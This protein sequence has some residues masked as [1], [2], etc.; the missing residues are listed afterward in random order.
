[1]QKIDR[2]DVHHVVFCAQ[3]RYRL[4]SRTPS[5]GKEC[6]CGQTQQKS[7]TIQVETQPKAVFLPRPTM[8]PHTQLTGL[9]QIS[10]LNFPSTIL[11]FGTQSRKV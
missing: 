9:L 6:P 2:S 7:V 1:M 4:D 8:G 5:R 3:T 10:V 11:T